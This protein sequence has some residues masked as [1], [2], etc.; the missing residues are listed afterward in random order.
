MLFI[1]NNN[2]GVS[3]E[4]RAMAAKASSSY[5]NCQ[6]QMETDEWNIHIK[7]LRETE[8]KF[9]LGVTD[10]GRRDSTYC[11]T[12]VH[13]IMLLISI[14]LLLRSTAAIVCLFL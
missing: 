4:K 12:A 10:G 7:G 11:C 13:M 8:F 14:I 9:K 6:Y 1:E 5:I 3:A 2:E